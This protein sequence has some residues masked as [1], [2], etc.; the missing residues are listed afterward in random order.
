MLVPEIGLTPQLVER[1]RERFDAPMAVLHSGLTDDER[2]LAWREAL[3]RRTRASCSARARRCSR[4]C[5]ELGLIVVDEEHDASFKQH[6]GGCA[7]RRAT[8]PWCARSQRGVPVVLGSATPA[9]ETLHNVAAGRY[10]R[11]RL[12]RRAAQA[13]PPR[14]ALIDLRA[15]AVHAGLATPAVLAIERHLA[16]DGQVLV[17]LNRRGYAPTLLCTAC[18]W[19]APCRECDARLTVHQAARPAALPPLRRGRAA[20]GALPAV[21]LRRASRSARAPSA[22][23]K[24]SR[25]CFPACRWR[26]STA[27]WCA[28]AATWRR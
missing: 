23:R 11:L 13:Q 26:A 14:L 1:F 12:P 5:R 16:A 21:R 19:I 28:S 9:L 2:L 27:T 15:H 10:T 17:F 20:A 18:G 4:R 24:R 8:W 25:R 7:T 3:Q 6:E 22:S